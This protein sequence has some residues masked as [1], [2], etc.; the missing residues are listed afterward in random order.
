VEISR[1]DGSWSVRER[2]LS[3][4]SGDNQIGNPSLNI[5]TAGIGTGVGV[6]FGNGVASGGT[7]L[8]DAQYNDRGLLIPRSGLVGLGESRELMF[9]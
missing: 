1:Q 2:R 9:Y 3:I 8:S 6:G 5:V 7:S 4:E